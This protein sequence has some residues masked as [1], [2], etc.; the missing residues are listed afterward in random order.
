MNTLSENNTLQH[1]PLTGDE[2]VPGKIAGTQY[3]VIDIIKKRWSPRSFNGTPLTEE[4]VLTLIEAAGRAPSAMNEQPW[5]FY[6]ALKD[7]PGFEAVYS[8]ILG[9]NKPWSGNAGAL[10]VVTA[11]KYYERNN[12][13][14]KYHFHDTGIATGFLLAQATAMGIGVH[15]LGG[16][17]ADVLRS[18][19]NFP[20]NEEIVTVI[21]A[22]YRDIPGQLDEPFRSRELQPQKRKPLS[23][24]ANDISN[25]YPAGNN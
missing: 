17:N 6:Y 25:I 1:T 22:G 21:V 9:G 16:F 14:N 12:S 11:G 24:T 13:L 23:V 3:P 15:I 20:Q 2:P 5:K 4:S 19:F 7:T 18:V 8:G 10:L